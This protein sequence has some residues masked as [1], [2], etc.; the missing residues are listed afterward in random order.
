MP[1][2]ASAGPKPYR[3]RRQ[4]STL[5]LRVPTDD[6]ARVKIGEKTA[7][8]MPNGSQSVRQQVNRAPLPTP[9]LA[10][11]LTPMPRY[12]CQLMVLEGHRL[13]PLYAL[14]GDDEALA[15]EGFP[16]YDHFR[17]YWRARWFGVWRE[18]ELVHVYEV[19][20]WTDDDFEEM[21]K[22]LLER[23]YG[24]FYGSVKPRQLQG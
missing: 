18:T 6:W 14:I 22:L 12:D 11:M 19:R 8:R 16:T 2:G 21:G 17:R 9:V 13:E 24:A 23:L 10:Y 15:R 1:T 5:Y 7:F 4:V 3:P 20:P